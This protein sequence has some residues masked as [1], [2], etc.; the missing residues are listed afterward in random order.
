MGIVA[1]RPGRATGSHRNSAGRLWMPGG[2]WETPTRKVRG[3]ERPIFLMQVQATGRE[4]FS[5]PPLHNEASS[6]VLRSDSERM[7]NEKM[8]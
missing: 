3:F 6:V 8:E 5:V 7:R 2:A 4:Y 1:I